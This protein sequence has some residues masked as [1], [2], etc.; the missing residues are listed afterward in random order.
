MTT[1]IMRAVGKGKSLPLSSFRHPPPSLLLPPQLSQQLASVTIICSCRCFHSWLFQPW[2]SQNS[3]SYS[4]IPSVDNKAYPALAYT[5]TL[6][7]HFI[8]NSVW[9]ECE[10]VFDR[11]NISCFCLLVTVPH[12]SPQN[13]RFSFEGTILPTQSTVSMA[14]LTPN[15]ASRCESDQKKQASSHIP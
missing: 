14:E 3:M 15:L 13:P 4:V 11:M 8:A 6:W 9:I 2:S 12:L 10:A 7:S 1:K 5:V